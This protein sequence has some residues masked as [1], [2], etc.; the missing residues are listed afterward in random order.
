[1]YYPDF[2]NSS[3]SSFIK[4]LLSSLMG[5]VRVNMWD[6]VPPWLYFWDRSCKNKHHL[7]CLQ[8]NAL[9]LFLGGCDAISCQSS[10]VGFWI[11]NLIK[12]V[13]EQ[14]TLYQSPVNCWYFKSLHINSLGVVL[15]FIVFQLVK[16][17]ISVSTIYYHCFVFLCVSGVVFP[18]GKLN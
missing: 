7:Y 10:N 16:W 12:T 1:M 11:Q 9:N 15:I 17:N 5:P 14:R 18:K 6:S 13:N 2:P 8:R 3:L 4:S